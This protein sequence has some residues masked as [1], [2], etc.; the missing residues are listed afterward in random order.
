MSAP[1]ITWPE[2]VTIDAS[3]A[4]VPENAQ[5]WILEYANRALNPRMFTTQAYKLVRLYLAAHFGTMSVPGAA[6]ETPVAG[7]VTSETVGGISRTYALVSDSSDPTFS[8]TSHGQMYAFLV[9][10][11]K[12]RL[13]F[14]LG[15]R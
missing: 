12:G 14:A 6:G 7:P 8:T 1:P 13:P 10:T 11:S 15:Q 4:T 5:V 3:L 9:R 2:V